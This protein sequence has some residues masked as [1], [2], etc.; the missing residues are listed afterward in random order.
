MQWFPNKATETRMAYPRNSLLLRLRWRKFIG[1]TF[2]MAAM[3]ILASVPG[4]A[5]ETTLNETGSTLLYPLFVTWVTQYTRTHPGVHVNL[6]ATGSEAGI[7]QVIAGK[8]NIGASDA[9][10]SD[11][12]IRQS[13]LIINVPLAIAAQTI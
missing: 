12:Q 10:M 2:G 11:A 7:Q 6:G 1:C 9:Y 4:F 13:P 5:Q 8:V 3:T